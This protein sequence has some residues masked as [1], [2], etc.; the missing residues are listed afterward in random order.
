MGNLGPTHDCTL[1][2]CQRLWPFRRFSPVIRLKHLDVAAMPQSHVPEVAYLPVICTSTADSAGLANEFAYYCPIANGRTD[3]PYPDFYS[4]YQANYE[5]V[6]TTSNPIR[7][8]NDDKIDVLGS[9]CSHQLTPSPPSEMHQTR[10]T[11]H[12]FSSTS[13]ADSI[14]SDTSPSCSLEEDTM[15]QILPPE[16]RQKVYQPASATH[17][18]SRAPRRN[19]N[20]LVQ[21]RVHFCTEP[22]K[23]TNCR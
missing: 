14:S 1:F 16:I 8:H 20:E 19:K 23:H 9:V 5:S 12:S 13:S 7:I 6:N 21:K 18:P 22:G 11:S 4:G 3:I 2:V 17:L 15:A 10:S